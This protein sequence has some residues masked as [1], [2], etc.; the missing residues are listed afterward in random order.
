MKEYDDTC[1]AEY[2]KRQADTYW[3]IYD[4]NECG[5]VR[6][7]MVLIPACNR[8]LESIVEEAAQFHSQC[9]GKDVNRDA[10]QSLFD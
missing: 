4:H 2:C 5:L 7:K 1:A 6:G 10:I 3:M 9:M 8:H